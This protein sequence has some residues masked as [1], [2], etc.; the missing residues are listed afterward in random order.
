MIYKNIRLPLN[1]RLMNWDGT[2]NVYIHVQTSGVNKFVVAQPCPN[3]GL[4]FS[5]FTI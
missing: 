4:Q 3:L 2:L 5:V 1:D